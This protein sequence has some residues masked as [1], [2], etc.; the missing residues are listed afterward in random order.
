V[1]RGPR[2]GPPPAPLASWS[3]PETESRRWNEGRS[4]AARVLPGLQEWQRRQP[5]PASPGQPNS[6]AQAC[7]D[8]TRACF[9]Q[10]RRLTAAAEPPMKEA[11]SRP[12][13]GWDLPQKSAA[14]AMRGRRGWQPPRLRP[15]LVAFLSAPSRHR[16]P[17]PRSRQAQAASKRR[18]GRAPQPTPLDWN[19]G[20]LTAPSWTRLR[21]ART[22]RPRPQSGREP[23]REDRPVC[24]VK[25]S[26]R[27]VSP[28]WAH[29][30]RLG[31]LPEVA[32]GEVRV[33]F[34]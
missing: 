21:A 27:A 34:G 32:S 6:V 4:R 1:P 20:L 7:R 15:T 16:P 9:A 19:V 5:R 3:C 17:V 13:G 10:V 11:G 2:P 26:G 30:I 28:G 24:P 31:R 8:G 29:S 18:Q 33:T 12:H 22:C 25:A 23:L 14:C